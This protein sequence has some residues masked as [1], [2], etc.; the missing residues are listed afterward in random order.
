MGHVLSWRFLAVYPK[1]SS[2][3]FTIDAWSLQ[4][5]HG[6]SRK[7]LGHSRRGLGRSTSNSNSNSYSDTGF[8]SNSNSNSSSWGSQMRSLGLQ[9]GAPGG[10]KSS[11]GGLQKRTF[12]DGASQ[13]RPRGVWDRPK[14]PIL[15]TVIVFKRVKIRRISPQIGSDQRSNLCIIQSM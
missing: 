2:G 4:L 12:R 3:G 5:H 9:N 15:E 11:P 14:C 13:E 1:W 10:P 8:N 7:G 6:R